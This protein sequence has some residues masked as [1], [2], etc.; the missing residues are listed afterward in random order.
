M[1]LCVN[2][3]IFIIAFLFV[4][5]ALNKPLR[6]PA[7]TISRIQTDSQL[8]RNSYPNHGMECISCHLPVQSSDVTNNFRMFFY[9]FIFIYLILFYIASKINTCYLNRFTNS[10]K[11][12]HLFGTI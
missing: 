8:Y 3:S 10:D 9:K 5:D 1:V 2:T 6:I 11:K 12:K 7:A 4:L